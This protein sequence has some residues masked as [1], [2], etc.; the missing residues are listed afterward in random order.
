[1]LTM[2]SFCDLKLSNHGDEDDLLTI[3]MSENIRLIQHLSY[4]MTMGAE[5]SKVSHEMTMGAE[6]SKS[7]TGPI[8][9]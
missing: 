5:V 1:M 3:N 9:R 6:V 8:G 4:E 2:A 7:V